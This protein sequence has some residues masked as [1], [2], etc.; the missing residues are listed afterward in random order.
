MSTFA[1]TFREPFPFSDG[2]V[3][4][5]REHY[6]TREEAAAEFAAYQDED[7]VDPVRLVEDRVRFRFPGEEDDLDWDASTRPQWFTGASGRGSKP[8]WVLER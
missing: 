4:L 8:V 2:S 3:V 1:A 6:P 7:A 5:S